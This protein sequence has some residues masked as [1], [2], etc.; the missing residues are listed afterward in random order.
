MRIVIVDGY[1]LNPGDLNWETIQGMGETIIYDRTEVRDIVER[2]KDADIV[3]TNKVPFTR[4]TLLQLPC[5]KLICVT[6]TGYNIIDTQA[7]RE[8]GLVVTNIPAYSTQSVAQTVIALLL[9]VT[10]RVEHYTNQITD[11]KQWSRNADFCYW[12][13][14]LTELADKRMGIYGFGR[15]GRQVS[16]IAQALGMEVVVHTSKPQEELPEGITKLTGDMFWETCDVISLHC[17]LTPE[18]NNLVNEVTLQKMKSSCILINTARGPLVNEAAIAEALS[19]SRLKAFCADV[20]SVEPASEDNP[21][22]QAP[23]VFLTPHIAWATLEARQRLMNILIANIRAF[24]DG[25]P[26]NVVN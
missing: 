14:Q 11:E 13:T 15:I 7:A 9:S 21:I 6:A 19:H 3:L 16:L 25:S 24:I 8:Q 4:E 22:L 20:L 17:P 18:T 23:N 5:L 26:I 10:N 12:D 1:A 2:C